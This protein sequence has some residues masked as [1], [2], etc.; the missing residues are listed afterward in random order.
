MT[1]KSGKKSWDELRKSVRDST[2]LLSHLK[3]TI[4]S[5]FVFRNYETDNGTRTRIYFLGIP[6]HSRENTLL[7]MDLPS[8]EET[9][10]GDFVP[11]ILDWELLLE[12]FET[13][14][15][16]GQLSREEQLMRERKRLVLYGITSFDVNEHQALF[17]FPAN[18]NLYQCSDIGNVVTPRNIA[19]KPINTFCHSARMDP[20]ICP[21]DVDL[22]A[23]IHDND[24]WVTNLQTG[25][26]KRLTF[27]HKGKNDNSLSTDPL[28]AGVPSFVIQEE[29]DR[30]TGYW[31]KPSYTPSTSGKPPESSVKTYQVLYEE[32]DESEVEVL[33]LFAPSTEDHGIDEYRYPRAGTTNAKSSLKILEFEVDGRGMVNTMIEKQLREPLC[34]LFPW[35]EYIV[36]AGWTPCGKYIYSHLLDRKQEKSVLLLIPIDNFIPVQ[37]DIDM[38][39]GTDNLQ[40]IQI[41]YQETSH[42]W[43][44]THDNL[45]FLPSECTEDSLSFIWSSE[46]SGYRHLYYIQSE[47]IHSTT[48]SLNSSNQSMEYDDKPECNKLQEKQITQG[49]WEVLSL[50]VWIDEERKIVYFTGLKDTPLETHLYY[51][52]YTNPGEPIRLTTLGYSHSVTMDSNLSMYVSVYSSLQ[53]SPRSTVNKLIFNN[54][55]TITTK[56]LAVLMEHT[57][58]Q[59]FHAPEMFNYQ[60][61][62]GCT[63]Y[64]MYYKPHHYQQG[65]KYPTVLFVYGGPQVQ[66]VSN[67]FKGLKFLRLHTLAAEGYAVVVIDCRGSSHRGLIYES[68]LKDSLGTV[69]IDEQVEGL[70]YLNSMV[71]FIDISRVAIHGWSYGGYLSLMG[72]AQRPEIFKCSIAGAPVVDWTL[73]DTGYT[74]R[75]LGLPT[76]SS[77][78]YQKGCVLHYINSFPDEE[79]RLLIIHG[80]ID[81]NV[82]FHHSNYLINSLV[83][84]CKPYQLQVYPNE[85]HGIR[86]HEASEHYKTM[87]LSFLQ[88]NL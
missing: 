43:I 77:E 3:S 63:N 9:E 87:V 56:C 51:V 86:G 34:E 30:H 48:S 69:E 58:C 36:R 73:Y 45:Q 8:H 49:D 75:Y 74:E 19:P 78:A 39:N 66:L 1:N 46:Q 10:K 13:A 17:V 62:S 53:Q 42:I 84:H 32:V 85:R 16:K 44:N 55:N 47:I 76:T 88:N 38:S 22:V 6:K 68:V 57:V 41:L 23:F 65:K 70:F 25:C 18:N 40:P 33:N 12:S 15:G 35:Y 2:R 28:S 50:P 81:E 71:D 5:A 14:S 80:L 67:S 27:A 54:N 26:E 21:T 24:V 79:N 4:P 7:F 37:S 61:T 29:F 64:G 20:K 82:H 31:W 52:S 11:Q 60:S 59:Q 72:L 83:K